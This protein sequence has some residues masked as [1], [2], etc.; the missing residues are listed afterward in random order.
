MRALFR[1]LRKPAR[2]HGLPEL[3]GMSGDFE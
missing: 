3:D 2:K 1:A